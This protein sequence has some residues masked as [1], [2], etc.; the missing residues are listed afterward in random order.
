MRPR[1]RR[2]EENSPAKGKH[3][4]KRGIYLPPFGD[5]ASPRRVAELAAT[6]EQTGWDGFFIWD[7]MFALPGMAVAEAW[8][9]LAAIAMS[10]ASIRLGALVTPLARR[11][12]W[13]LA[14]QIATI[15]QLCAGRLVVGVGLGDDGWTEFSAFG[16][17]TSPRARGEL[18]DESLE[19]LLQLLTGN[20]VVYSGSR[21]TIDSG[22]VLPTP[23]QDPVPVWSGVRWPNRKP[24]ARAARLQGC[25]PIFPGS[26]QRPAPPPL[27]DLAAL[28]AEL[29]D[30][31]APRSLDVVVP[32]SLM[33]L[34]PAER[35]GV[36]QAMAAAGATWLLEGFGVGQNGAE[37]EAIV[38]AGPPAG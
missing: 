20:A 32:C 5:F 11:R 6:A 16:E 28:R 4:V 10:T 34:D 33:L 8:T 24:L 23:V 31:G 35:A 17:E 38:A 15:D 21:F 26:T 19:I 29:T 7:H 27:A 30:L 2:P 1:T 14:R 12:P 36:V 9:T 13:V 18:L 25:F 3:P 37:V 22:P